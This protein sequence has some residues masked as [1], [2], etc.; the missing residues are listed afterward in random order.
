[1]AGAGTGATLTDEAALATALETTFCTTI[2][3]TFWSAARILS[4]AVFELAC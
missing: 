2:W 3:V 1:M 4:A